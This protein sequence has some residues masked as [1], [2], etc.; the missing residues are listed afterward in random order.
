EARDFGRMVTAV[1]KIGPRLERMFD[2]L[3]MAPGARPT[4]PKDGPA[5]ADPQERALDQLRAIGP[6]PGFDQAAFVDP[7]V[8]AAD[9]GD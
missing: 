3:G 2:L 7:S 4:L 5:D 9:A 1:S 6:A 8:T